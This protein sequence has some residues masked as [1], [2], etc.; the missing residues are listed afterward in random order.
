MF[1]LENILLLF[2]YL[3][4]VIHCLSPILLILWFTFFFVTY[5]NIYFTAIVTYLDYAIVRFE[6]FRFHKY[7][8]FRA[9]STFPVVS[10]PVGLS[11]KVLLASKIVN[12]NPRIISNSFMCLFYKLVTV[13]SPFSCTHYR[14]KGRI[15]VP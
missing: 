1:K 10:I 13:D 12:P 9:E 14:Y 6:I 3:I 4:I 11:M 15:G 8:V 2:G 5:R 7:N